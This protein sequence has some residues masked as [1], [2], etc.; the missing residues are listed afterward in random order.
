MSKIK[1]GMIGAGAIART[2]CNG[3]NKHAEA[4]MVAVADLSTARRNALKQEFG[5]TRA[6]KD[7]DAL[8]ADASIDAVCIAL[9][10]AL[11]APF[12]IKALEAG[13]HVML[14]K[15][16]ALNVAE[17]RQMIA[18]ARKA[19][20]VL[21]VGM[22]QRYTPDSQMIRTLVERGELGDI[23]HAKAVW[24]R[25]AGA[26]RFGTWFGDKRL[27]GGGCLLDIGVHLLDLCL[28]VAGK[29]EPVSASGAVY[30]KYGNRGI[31][32]GGWGHSDRKKGKHRFDVDD[33]ATA[34]IRFKDGCTV[35]LTVSWVL[36]QAEANMLDLE[37]FG[38]EAGASARPARVFRFGKKPNEY[39]VVEPQGVPMARP[40]C[41]RHVDWID[42]ILGVAEPICTL[43]Q[44]LTVQKVLDAI[45]R[46]SE[47][48]REVRIR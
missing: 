3:V 38:T 23:Y 16:F 39:E 12:T 26:P 19:R 15:P 4:E 14:D 18:A 13:K 44:A 10:N 43:D 21:T 36:Q 7:A 40:A 42:G 30:T 46:S 2:H 41:D 31:G 28:Y 5:L 6:Y 24:R 22:N 8:L 25:R 20:R 9:P 48:G 37:L 29:W 1:V 35:D 32:E 47:T 33:A 45:Y 17:A 34:L 27:A 11:H